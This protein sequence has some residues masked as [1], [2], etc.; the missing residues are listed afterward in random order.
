MKSRY[1]N[2]RSLN[3]QNNIS[4][5]LFFKS[6]LLQAKSANNEANNS[7]VP[8]SEMASDTYIIGNEIPFFKPVTKIRRKCSSCEE[9]DAKLQMKGKTTG[10]GR[11]DGP[12]IV[13]KVINSAGHP[14]DKNTRNFMESRFGY[15]FG[16]VQVHNDSLAHKSSK[17]INALA[18]THR[19]H[20]V[21][22]SEHFRPD[23]DSGKELLAH[24]L[25]HVVQ[26]SGKNKSTIQKKDDKKKPPEK[27]KAPE[28]KKTPARKNLIIVGEGWGGSEELSKVLGLKG[29]IIIKVNSVDTLIGGL[30]KIDY[31][32]STIY[33]ITHSMQDGSIKFGT[34]EG[35]V[36]PADIISKLKGSLK[37]EYAPEHVDF[38]G[39]NIG[40][41]PAVMNKFGEA[42]GAK[43]VTA[44]NCFAVI[45]LSTPIKIGGSEIKKASD[46]D[47]SNKALFNKLKTGTFNKFNER[48][49]C[50]LN[51]SDN[52]FFAAGG[53]FVLLW[54]NPKP[55][56][57]W[58]PGESVCFNEAGT[59]EIDPNKAVAAAKNCQLIKVVMK[60]SK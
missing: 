44:G 11:M 26:Q 29:G 28:K 43:G 59:Q 23:T 20:I 1:Q 15:D 10:G 32:V 50:I 19:N 40:N 12:A 45:A 35:Y 27:K 3:S 30:K 6:N 57:E 2:N 41:D 56:G 53:V 14:I 51:E 38:K 54:F 33:V 17:N 25:V 55:S 60:T 18:Y 31:P 58:L 22:S 21:F 4:T 16:N 49:K 7:N 47:P 48:K 42:I 46:V 5:R 52:G 13:H 39:C 24:E 37:E 8:K 36:K 9:E 34:K